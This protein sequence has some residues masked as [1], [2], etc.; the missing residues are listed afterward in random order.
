MGSSYHPPPLVPRLSA[1]P[2]HSPCHRLLSSFR[3]ILAAT[4]VV[5]VPWTS[6]VLAPAG[7][8]CRDLLT[9]PV[10]APVVP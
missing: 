8:H 2:F 4:A 6:V 3:A 9:V 10:V 7:S 1:P 5:P